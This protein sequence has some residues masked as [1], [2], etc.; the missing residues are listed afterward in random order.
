MRVIGTAGHV[1][2]GKS[3]LVQRLTGIQPDRLAEEQARQMTIDL[4]FAWM[5]LSTGEVLGIVDVPGHRDFIEN[6]L[7]GVGG[8]DAVIL[9]IAADEGVMPQT[10]EHL[11]I[12]NLLEIPA[13][14]I[15]LTKMDMIDDPEWLE[16]IELDIR[17]VIQGT[18]LKDAP[19]HSISAVTGDGIREL[20]E[21]LEALLVSLPEQT[22]IGQP[23]LS[24]DR[25]FS[26]SGFGT[27]VTGTLLGGQL[28]VGD[29]VELQPGNVIGRVRSLQSYQQNVEIAQP[30]SRVAVNLSGVDKQDASRGQTLAYPDQIHP[31]RMMDVY[32]RHL[33]DTQRPL[34]H[35][36]QVKI[37]VGAAESTARVRLLSH[38]PLLPGENGWLQLRLDN[39][40][41]VARNDRYITRYPSPVETIG[42]GIVVDPHP[43]HK[44]KRFQA[45]IIKRLETR[46]AGSPAERLVQAME[47][48]E[49]FTV[50]NLKQHV[51]M[52][53]DTLGK[54]LE[55]A[56]AEAL[57]ITLGSNLYMASAQYHK[58]QN[59]IVE[60]VTNFHTAEPL[61]A[62]ISREE[63]RSRLGIKGNTLT[64]LLEHQDQIM[65][66]GANLGLYNHEITFS[67]AQQESVQQLTLIL[68][69]SPFAPPSYKELERLVGN[70]VLRAL[71]E[72]GDLVQISSDL[73]FASGAYGQMVDEIIKMIEINGS[74]DAKHVRDR[75]NTSRKYAIGLLEHL[76][77]I[78]V[79]RRVGDER[80]RGNRSF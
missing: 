2:H 59:R 42:G 63:L 48:V 37:F 17:E 34:K 74:T 78:G 28:R 69:Q 75:F 38:D 67:E 72:L 70:D 62:G 54:A 61:R 32:F 35:N 53:E 1:D 50:N 27:I 22:N 13:G 36:A 52:D 33:S 16:L 41:P 73:V 66:H 45:A 77:S 49:P 30:G 39:P 7:A 24:V 9:T 65:P 29:E 10:Y 60:V 11:A 47:G 4:G 46:Q 76:D 5:P 19:I 20:V 12:L 6:M 68:E 3:T 64:L 71:I 18:V 58:L 79:T 25:V 23:R 43:R 31:T 56:L 21:A 14:L 55:E 15:A 44:W 8:I 26:K 57:V 40:L 80:V 51:D